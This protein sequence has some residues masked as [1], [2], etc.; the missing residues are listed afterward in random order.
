MWAKILRYLPEF[1]SGV[2]TGLD[3]E[4]RPLSVRCRPQ[5]DPE[6]GV[7][8]LALPEALA[9]QAGPA[10]LLFHR[11]DE[12][13][14]NLLSFVVRGALACD[15]GGWVVRPA[16]FVSGVGIGGLMSYVHFLVDGRRT[17][18]HYLRQRGLARPR[19]AW[20]EWLAIIDRAKRA[21]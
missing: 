8:R 9:I 6:A 11:H 19:I 7:L 3:S 1:E 21:D 12:R 2:L 5:P 14:W 15:G 20:Q 18:T 10:C 16:R 17:T 13:L 4:G